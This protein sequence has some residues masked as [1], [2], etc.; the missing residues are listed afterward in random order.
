MAVFEGRSRKPDI[1]PDQVCTNTSIPPLHDGERIEEWEPFFTA[2]VSNL[3]AKG[4]AGHAM[5]K[6]ML[7]AYIN[8]R[9][10]EREL[11][12]EVIARETTLPAA[13][14]V[15]K[16]TLDPPLD[17]YKTMRELCRLDWCPGVMVDD[18]FFTLKRLGKHADADAQMICTLLVL[19]LPDEVRAKAEAWLAENRDNLDDRKMNVFVAHIKHWLMYKGLALDLGAKPS[20]VTAVPQLESAD[21]SKSDEGE[22]GVVTSVSSCNGMRSR[23]NHV[24]D[25]VNA[26]GAMVQTPT[27]KDGNIVGQQMDKSKVSCQVGGVEIKGSVGGGVNTGRATVQTATNNEAWVV[28]EQRDKSKVRRQAGGVASKSNQG[29]GVNNGEATLRT[30]MILQSK[31]DCIVGDQMAKSKA[32]RQVGA[33]KSNKGDG[34]TDGRATL[35]T[36]TS[37]E[38]CVVWEQMGKSVASRQVGGGANRSNVG[39][40]VSDH[41]KTVQPE[42][43]NEACIVSGQ[44]DKSK[45]SRQSAGGTNE[46]K[47]IRT[48]TE[49]VYKV[50]VTPEATEQTDKRNE[51]TK[52]VEQ[53]EQRKEGPGTAGHTE[54]SEENGSAGG[55]YEPTC[56]NCGKTGH[57]MRS[58]PVQWCSRCRREI[59]GSAVCEC[60]RIVQRLRS[61]REAVMMTV[62]F[63]FHRQSVLINPGAAF[64]MI[65]SLTVCHLNMDRRVCSSTAEHPNTMKSMFA[66]EDASIRASGV[67][68]AQVTGKLWVDVGVAHR[69]LPINLKVIDCDRRFI[70]LGRDFLCGFSSVEFDGAGDRVRLGSA[71]VVP[72]SWW[73]SSNAQQDLE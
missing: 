58:C 57:L 32:S 14:Q 30:G 4:E 53:T 1:V 66:L 46:G 42:T 72:D 25:G 20:N 54:K 59:R 9:T 67:S 8:R 47:E 3:L 5:A 35:Q 31:E 56:W 64:S 49:Q 60:I 55:W 51:G 34:A 44:M 48:T 15:L 71:W 19:Q 50:R 45:V 6:S 24:G 61:V 22:R 39:D 18:F 33:N 41:R 43:S 16:D 10:A 11:V 17:K 36:V 2:A 52:N 40:G 69:I 29:D 38:P 26:A 21:A 23:K 65:D 63:G 27:S 62:K 73:V 12:K 28:G 37:K 13:F 7:P 70:V 68:G